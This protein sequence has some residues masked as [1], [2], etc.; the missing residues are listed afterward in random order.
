MRERR[1]NVAAAIA[2]ATIAEAT[3]AETTIAE[4]TIAAGAKVDAALLTQRKQCGGNH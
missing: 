4:A 3:I 2:E 1:G